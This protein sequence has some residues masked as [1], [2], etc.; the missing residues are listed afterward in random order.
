MER[1]IATKIYNHFFTNNLLSCAQHRFV[2][3]RS[4]ATNLME[5]TN[6]WTLAVQEKQAIMFAYID[7]SRAFDTVSHDK[8]FVRLYEYDIRGQLLG[9]LTNIFGHRTHQ[10]RIGVAL[11][12]VASLWCCAGEWYRPS[13]VYCVYRSTCQAAR[14]KSYYSLIICRLCQRVFEN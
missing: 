4:T 7:F 6:D 9:W 11:S 12:S 13:N 14:K 2:K 10:T 1:V 3:G 5:A 8:L